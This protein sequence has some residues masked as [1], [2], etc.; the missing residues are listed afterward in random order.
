MDRRDAT[1]IDFVRWAN[2]KMNADHEHRVM[3]G[4]ELAREYVSL[5]LPGSEPGLSLNL[6]RLLVREF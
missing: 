5:F 3:S 4:I 6:A 2:C 1:G